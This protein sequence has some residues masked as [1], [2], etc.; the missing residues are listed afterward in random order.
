VTGFRD[1]DPTAF[2]P[3]R[4]STVVLEGEGVVTHWERPEEVAGG[5]AAGVVG[6]AEGERRS[7]R[8]SSGERS[9]GGM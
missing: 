6:V 3:P 8:A 4:H 7:G 9:A 5:G 1:A 2:G